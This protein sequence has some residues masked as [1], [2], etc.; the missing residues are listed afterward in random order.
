LEEGKAEG[1]AGV[2]ARVYPALPVEA[3]DDDFAELQPKY[4]PSLEANN[5]S[6]AAVLHAHN[7]NGGEERAPRQEAMPQVLL[8]EDN[9][10]NQKVATAQ[11]NRLGY[12]VHAVGNGREAVEAVER[13]PYAV[14]LMDCQMPEMDGFEAT[15]LIRA[16]EGR[17]DRKVRIIA[18]TANA[19]HGDREA[20]LQAGM[21][22]YIA[23]P[24]RVDELDAILKKWI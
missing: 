23:K 15:R 12:A 13:Q 19:M 11:L 7:G 8:V 9:H 17:N 21:N 5:G 6:Y 20:C 16:W 4:L 3:A 18:M 2:A 14:V 1:T 24:I 22:D 10:V